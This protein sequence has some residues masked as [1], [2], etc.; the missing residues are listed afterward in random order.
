[1]TH[2]YA[3]LEVPAVVYAAVKALL[4][5][6]H[7]EHAFSKDGIIDMHGIALASVD[8]RTEGEI[9][10]GT[11]LSHKTGH[12]RIEFQ[13][14]AEVVQL[15]IDKAKMIVGMFHEA[16]EAAISDELIFKFLTTRIGLSPEQ[17]AGALVDFRELRQGSRTAVNPS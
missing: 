4:T 11:L 17:A 13:I 7:Y 6:A 10:I 3:V 9:T 16:I 14:G 2:T 12:G 5:R 8:A 1:M 15:D